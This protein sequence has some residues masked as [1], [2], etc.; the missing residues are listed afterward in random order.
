MNVQLVDKFVGF[1]GQSYFCRSCGRAGFKSVAA[2]RG[3][4]AFCSKG[5]VLPPVGVAAGAGAGAGL[6]GQEAMS[7][8]VSSS[9]QAGQAQ[10]VALNDGMDKRY[11]SMMQD[12]TQRLDRIEQMLYNEVPHQ[13]AVVQAQRQSFDDK[14][15][16]WVIVGYIA[17]WLLRKLGDDSIV[18]KAGSKIGDKM[19]GKAIDG[20]LG[21]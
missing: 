19:L 8:M 17:I 11:W 16:K 4:L 20:F 18:K 1:D 6:R 7:G 10:G 2:V 13:V 12:V 5:R 15:V 9:F 14:W 21:L 3:H